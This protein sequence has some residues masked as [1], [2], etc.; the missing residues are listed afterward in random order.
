[1]FAQAAAAAAGLPLLLYGLY[2]CLVG[3]W[4]SC[5]P[6]MGWCIRRP[7]A[8]WGVQKEQGRW[9]S[10]CS[11]C[12]AAVVAAGVEEPLAVLKLLELLS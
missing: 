12:A 5:R 11:G 6:S 9:C 10:G 2:D 1:M 3:M 8:A 4:Q 7:S